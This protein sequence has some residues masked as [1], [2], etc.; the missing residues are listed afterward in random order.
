MILL[1]EDVE[2]TV[3]HGRLEFARGSGKM[4]R[5]NNEDVLEGACGLQADGLRR[6]W[7]TENE[8]KM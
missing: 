1:R 4:A 3:L 8:D 6:H 5:D 7:M 2:R